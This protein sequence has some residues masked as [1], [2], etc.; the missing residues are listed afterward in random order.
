MDD[1]PLREYLAGEIEYIELCKAVLVRQIKLIESDKYKLRV[2]QIRDQMK[3]IPDSHFHI[4]PEVFIQLSGLTEFRFPH[5]GFRLYPDQ[6]CVMPRGIS[7]NEKTG[8]WRGGFY[9]LVICAVRNTNYCL[10]AQADSEQRPSVI[11]S[12]TFEPDGGN[13]LANFLD[14]ITE[15]FHQE[16]SGR[17]WRLKGAL[18]AAFA[19]V[20]EGLEGRRYVSHKEHFAVARCK[21]LIA[22]DFGNCKLSVEYLAGVLDC[23][24]D[25]LSHLFHKETSTRL[26]SYINSER[27]NRA[28]YLLAATALNISETARACGYKDP[29]YFAR[30]FGRITGR[31]PRDF[32]GFIPK[33]QKYLTADDA[34]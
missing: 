6:I 33:E 34:D 14:D 9:D 15:T 18:L 7:H 22:D 1:N 32:R 12:T 16:Q 30:V 29:A 10:L 13:R 21:Q 24:A 2:P 20:L 5:E 4:H 31:S 17:Q 26:T 19:I 11:A 25:Y 23:S 3:F 28:K 27:V 8:N